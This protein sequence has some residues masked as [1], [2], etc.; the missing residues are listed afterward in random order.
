MR[1]SDTPLCFIIRETT[2]HTGYNLHIQP[3][4]H[5]QYSGECSVLN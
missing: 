3:G 2:L 1:V 4:A 5:L